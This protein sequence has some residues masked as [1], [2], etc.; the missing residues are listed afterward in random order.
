MMTSRVKKIFD[1]AFHNV[2]NSYSF[3]AKLLLLFI[4][5]VSSCF[6]QVPQDSLSV[7]DT[8]TV[9][10]S[11]Y[12][13]I[14]TIPFAGSVDR[15][16]HEQYVLPDSIIAFT[17]YK[18]LGD[19][20]STFPGVYMR[21]LGSPGQLHGLTI[22]GV[23]A[24][25]VAIMSDGILLN[26]PLTGIFDLNL[27]PT[28]QIERIEMIPGTRAFLYGLNSTGGAVN[29]VTK[30]YQAVAPISRIRYDQSAYDYSYFDGLVSQD[31]RRDL[32]VTLGLQHPGFGGRFR[33]NTYDAW[34][35][36]SK[37]R[38]NVSENLNLFASWMYNQTRL[39]LNGGVDTATAPA[40]RFEEYSV[41]LRNDDAYE[42]ITRHDLQLGMAAKLFPD[43][44]DVTTFTLFHTTHLREYRDEEQ[45]FSTNM[46][47]IQQDHWS[48]WYG[49]RL[50][51]HVSLLKNE[52]DFTG[53]VQSRGVIASPTIGQQIDDM[54]SF[55]A[56]D[57]L[58]LFPELSLAGYIRLDKYNKEPFR[59]S[60]GADVT[61]APVPWGRVF[62]GYSNSDRW[63]TFLE[64]YWND[65][66]VMQYRQ[67]FGM[68]H[69][70]LIETGISIQME[71]IEL[72]LTY[73]NRMITDPIIYTQ[74]NFY[75]PFPV[76]QVEDGKD[77]TI[78]GINGK[79]TGRI[80]VLYTEGNFQYLKLG[81]AGVSESLFPAWSASGGIYFWDTLF[82]A[83]LDLKVGFRG[84]IISSHDGVEY[85]PQ[86]QMYVPAYFWN[87]NSVGVGD[88]VLQAR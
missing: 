37:I 4:I 28:E 21:D 73:F 49:A 56:K 35:I 14:P 1:L 27:Y 15:I 11:G 2:L 7:Q 32:N 42:K 26:D 64:R 51:Q 84:R 29:L 79:L 25:S 67:G 62:A 39:S 17:D 34:N 61:I 10:D 36:R 41:T 19:L 46:I 75:N 74:P 22:N 5:I 78:Q 18:Y 20:L 87:V 9:Q 3:P 88:F 8:T 48:Q 6:A 58:A 71:N 72:W 53:E 80:G 82:N 47:F 43:S 77:Y 86:A 16:I 81:D 65:T 23:D 31:V 50:M 30:N 13:P 83:H 70:Q 52:L 54:F 76:V 45:L 68:E 55:T 38:Y 85:N 57:E 24:R 60:Y 69:H 44:Q 12:V 40:I 33:N 63:L 59:N 66:I